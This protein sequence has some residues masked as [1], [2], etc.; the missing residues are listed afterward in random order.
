MTAANKD[1]IKISGTPPKFDQAEYQRRIDIDLHRYHNTTDS[2]EHVTASLSH[3]FLEAVV[4]K[5]KAG[6]TIS[7]GYRVVMEPLN[8]SCYVK[9]PDDIQALD[10]EAIHAKV[11]G[12]YVAWL[13]SEH[14]RYQDLLRQQLIQTQQEKELKAA[15]EKEAKQMALIEKQVLE[16]FTPL[17][18]PE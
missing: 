13:H 12:E 11:K 14:A 15:A 16:C 18:I 9:K 1:K 17:H 7:R 5:V 3:D 8:Y 6:Y 4:E 10:I 2:L